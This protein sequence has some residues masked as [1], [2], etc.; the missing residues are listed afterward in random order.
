MIS[1]KQVKVIGVLRTQK[2][3]R[4]LILKQEQNL[5]CGPKMVRVY[6]GI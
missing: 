4:L 5:F 2:L 6:F 3:L 1:H